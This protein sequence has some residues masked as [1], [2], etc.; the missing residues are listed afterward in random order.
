[1]SWFWYLVVIAVLLFFSALFSGSETA[2]FSLTHAKRDRLKE[3]NPKNA[4]RVENFLAKP[5][6]LLGTILLANLLVNITA[7]SLFTLAVIAYTS[8]IGQK[9]GVYLGV[10]GLVM[11]GALLVFGEVTPK[12]MA[13]RKPESFVRF[14]GAILGTVRAILSPAVLVLTKIGSAFSPHLREPAYLTE[15]ELHTMIKHGRKRGVITKREEEILWN[16]V[17]LEERT[18]SEVMTPRIDM[19][20]LDKQTTIR[21]AAATCLKHGLSRLP[22]YNQTVDNIIGIAY[23]KEFLTVRDDNSPVE[24]IMRPAYFVPEAKKLP[25]LLDELRKKGS[26]TAVV[27]DEFGQTAGLVTLEDVLEAILGEITDEFDNAA[28]E[29]PYF[30]QGPHSY[31]V[32]GE[33]DIATLNRLFRGAFEGI[34][35]ERLSGYIQE[36][37]GRLAVK[38]DRITV[39]GLECVVQEV[40]GNKLEKVLIKKAG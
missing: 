17:G 30:K 39:N 40:D 4:R 3:T 19:V 36:R 9:P 11:T 34:E 18:V 6:R 13:T 27:V 32:E 33:V 31:I 2:L 26:H 10:G 12:V 16:L 29:L 35:Q 1:M 14:S 24:K 22:V 21:N 7:S 8:H 20:C 28:R 37:L 15:E 5:T 23:A 38:G 25:P